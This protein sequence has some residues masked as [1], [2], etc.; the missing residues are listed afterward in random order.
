MVT[1]NSTTIQRQTHH[2]GRCRRYVL[3]HTI[4]SH[5]LVLQALLVVAKYIHRNAKGQSW[6]QFALERSTL[7]MKHPNRKLLKG[8][9]RKT[10][11][12]KRRLICK[13]CVDTW[14]G[15][16]RDLFF[17]WVGRQAP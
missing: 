11:K 7:L 13:V 14:F 17:G 5:A 1:N 3:L 8:L 12:R 4:I 9:Q 2:H 15:F 6:G 16:V 10:G